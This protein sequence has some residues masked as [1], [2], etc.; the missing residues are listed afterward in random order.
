MNLEKIWTDGNHKGAAA[1]RGMVS[2]PIGLK[3]HKCPKCQ[4]ENISGVL[5]MPTADE[6]DPNI[7]CIDCGY[8][9]D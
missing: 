2:V 7:I 8:W 1:I 5:I 9:W 4:S 6:Q 3:D